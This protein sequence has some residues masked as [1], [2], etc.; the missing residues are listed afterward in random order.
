MQKID[1]SRIDRLANEPWYVSTRASQKDRFARCLKLIRTQGF[2]PRNAYDVG[3]ANG[4]FSSLLAGLG[5]A[6]T[7]VDIDP[8]RIRENRLNYG[9][10]EGLDFVCEDFLTGEVAANAVD[11]ITALEVLYYFTD[12]QQR[13]F[14][15]KAYDSLRPRGR[16]LVSVNIFFTGHFSEESLL[17]LIDGR[18][19]RVAVDRI[20]RNWYYRFELPLIEWLDQIKYLEKLRL[21]SP[22]ILRLDRKFYPG[23]WN[24]ILL[25]PSR[26]MD[27]YLLPGLRAILLRLL[28]SRLIYRGVT[29]L[30]RIF[31]PEKGQSQM[32]ILLEKPA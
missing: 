24:R 11:L 14:F 18:F 13:L 21:F 9:S 4:Q 15:Q 27:R 19:D 30:T 16:L 8:V 7:G 10:T 22:N 17:G 6:V 32:I 12:E 29:E 5:A 20:Y 3:C 1:D 25:R 26:V 31:S 2:S 28:E 23:I